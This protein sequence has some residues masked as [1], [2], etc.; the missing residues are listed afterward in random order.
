MWACGGHK[1][2]VYPLYSTKN[3][4]LSA[5]P[6]SASSDPGDAYDLVEKK[7]GRRPDGDLSSYAA[8]QLHLKRTK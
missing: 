4:W 7:K 1:K 5:D 8:D 2:L 3:G 6:A